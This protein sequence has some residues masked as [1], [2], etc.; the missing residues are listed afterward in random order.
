MNITTRTEWVAKYRGTNLSNDLLERMFDE[1]YQAGYT[2]GY[3]F[4]CE[5]H[6]LKQTEPRTKRK[7]HTISG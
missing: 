7:W 2:S 3:E 4:G 1:A 6:K 5:T